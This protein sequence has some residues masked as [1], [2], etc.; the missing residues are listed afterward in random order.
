M[1]HVSYQC[2]LCVCLCVCLRLLIGR[3]TLASCLIRPSS[4]CL[5]NFYKRFK[6]E[7]LYHCT[8][9]TS[10]VFFITS[11]PKNRNG[12]PPH[13]GY[14]TQKTNQSHHILL[15]V[16]SMSSS[17]KSEQWP[18]PLLQG[19]MD[20]NEQTKKNII[21]CYQ[22]ICWAFSAACRWF[23]QELHCFCWL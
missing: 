1:P 14:C 23:H 22:W 7:L 6:L 2:F 17:Q 12:V 16:S 3:F 8:C 21:T 10:R 15:L 5:I 19:K 20:K 18:G 9:F 11:I 13:F 4:Y